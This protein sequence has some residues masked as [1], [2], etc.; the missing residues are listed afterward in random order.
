MT[1]T[2]RQGKDS[3]N[4]G[5]ALIFVI[6]AFVIIIL[7]GVIVFLLLRGGKEG[8]EETK[9][10]ARRDTVVTEENVEEVAEDLFSQEYVPPGYFS[11]TMTNVWHFKTGD[12]ESDDAYVANDKAN[13]NDIFFDLFL[14]EDEENPIYQSPVI[15]LGGELKNIK[16][17]TELKAGTYDC[18]MIYHLIDEEQNTLSTVRVGLTIEIAN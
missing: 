8:K 1:K 11:A 16:L 6:L 12:A 15:P 17:N 3:S 2:S 14:S 18:V 13:S 10:E 5:K 9:E 4:E 7:I